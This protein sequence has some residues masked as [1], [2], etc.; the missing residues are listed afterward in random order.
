MAERVPSPQVRAEAAAWL[1]RLHA[2]SRD[3]V[4]EAGFRDWLNASPDHAAAFEA[5]DRM[6]SDVGGL[7]NFPSDLRN[8]LGRAPQPSAGQASRRALL[9]GV[10]LLAVAGGSA[11]F[12]R[13]AS[14]KVY[15]T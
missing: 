12:W 1:A 15:E 9:A 6:W 4:D 5:V 3:A 10:G 7:H 13:S 11:L 2:E 8:S 14:A